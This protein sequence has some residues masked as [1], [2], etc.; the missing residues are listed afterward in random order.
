MLLAVYLMTMIGAVMFQARMVDERYEQKG[1]DYQ[2]CPFFCMICRYVGLRN[3]LPVVYAALDFL[4]C[5]A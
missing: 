4:R 1:M 5:C 2:L 3:G